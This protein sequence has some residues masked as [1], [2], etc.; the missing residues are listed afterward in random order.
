MNVFLR[1]DA[2]GILLGAIALNHYLGGSWWWFLL[3]VVLPDLSL[4][5][6]LGREPKSRW[7]RLVYNI[8]HTYTVPIFLIIALW[9]LR[10]VFLTGWVVHIALDRILGYGFKGFRE[11]RIVHPA[12]MPQE[13]D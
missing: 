9:A 3:C 10:P 5:S 2:L 4:L 8:A 1:L 7:P 12:P 6:Y 13:Q 11:T